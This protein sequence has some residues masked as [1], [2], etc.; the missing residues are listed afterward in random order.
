MRKRLTK[1]EIEGLLRSAG[2]D[3]E[4]YPVEKELV[5]YITWFISNT[6]IRGSDDGR[7]LIA[8]DTVR[9]YLCDTDYRP[10]EELRLIEALAPVCE[11]LTITRMYNADEHVHVS[12][13]IAELIG[14]L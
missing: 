8:E 11:S 7:H 1:A 6:E 12:E 9:M 14:K 2:F 5:P 13:V 3:P 4:Y 10:E